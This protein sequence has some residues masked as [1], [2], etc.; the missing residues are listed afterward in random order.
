[1]NFLI[2]INLYQKKLKIFY[3][4]KYYLTLEISE[5]YEGIDL[6]SGE[7]W[8]AESIE[9]LFEF[10]YNKPIDYIPTEDDVVKPNRD[11]YKTDQAYNQAL[12]AFKYNLPQ[13]LQRHIEDWRFEVSRFKH[14]TKELVGIPCNETEIRKVGKITY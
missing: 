2:V 3:K 8:A 7:I 14:Y 1:M 6:Y 4:V 5:N 12:T 11:N 10:I 9:Q 13:K